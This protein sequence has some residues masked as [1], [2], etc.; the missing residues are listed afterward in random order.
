MIYQYYSL[1]KTHQQVAE[2]LNVGKATVSRTIALFDETGTVSKRK[3]PVSHSEKHR[4]LTNVDKLLII[5]FTVDNPGVFLHE[6]Q[7]CLLEE[8]GTEVSI[9]TICKFLHNE[10][11]FTRQRMILT[12]KQRDESLRVEYLMDINVYVGHPE[13]F[14]FIDETG[15]DSRDRERKFGYSL[16]GRPAV[17][18]KLLF[19][20]QRIS[21]IAAISYDN[22]LLN[23][24][25]VA[26][27]VD[28]DVF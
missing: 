4:K 6:I 23:C 27:T 24:Y 14:V 1:R 17:C 18:S 3:Y 26:G 10:A 11:G 19:R 13:F 25:S 2:N 15:S 22:G 21:A 16:R 9:S 5:D 8:H 20:G 12:A 7:Q 28:G